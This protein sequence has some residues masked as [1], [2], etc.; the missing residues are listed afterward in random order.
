MMVRH[1]KE[2]KQFVICTNIWHKIEIFEGKALVMLRSFFT[3]IE[4][5]VQ[6]QYDTIPKFVNIINYYAA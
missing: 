5:A 1:G 6:M 2:Q 4:V 3:L